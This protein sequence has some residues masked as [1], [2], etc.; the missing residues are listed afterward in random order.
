MTDPQHADKA[1]GKWMWWRINRG[2]LR[3]DQ[4]EDDQGLDKGVGMATIVTFVL[5]IVGIAMAFAL[6]AKDSM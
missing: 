3:H 5:L 2:S 1:V 6:A 4:E